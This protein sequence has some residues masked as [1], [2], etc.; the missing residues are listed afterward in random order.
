[1]ATTFKN[2]KGLTEKTN[3][4][5]QQLRSSNF[6]ELTSF[7]GGQDRG[8][9]L[10]LTS[11]NDHVQLTKQQVKGLMKSCLDFLADDQLTDINL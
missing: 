8:K 6:I 5:G 9:C 1:M 10:Q 4:D 11:K 3:I 2:I 7:W